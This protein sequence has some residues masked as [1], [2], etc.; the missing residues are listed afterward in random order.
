M[1]PARDDEFEAFVDASSTRLLRAARLLVGD[2][3]RSED[4]L[5]L[6]LM[7][8]A[9]HWRRARRSPGAYARR[10]LINAS[11]DA[12]RRARARVHEEPLADAD[13]WPAPPT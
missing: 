3:Q 10:V 4:L 9:R 11:R 1:E 6:A 7:R 12:H 13:R 2:R 8:T 5:Q